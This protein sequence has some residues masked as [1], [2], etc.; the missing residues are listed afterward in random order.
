MHGRMG[1]L[2][3]ASPR[4]GLTYYRFAVAAAGNRSVPK[5]LSAAGAACPSGLSLYGTLAG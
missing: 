2:P 3:V 4:P 1:W 5:L